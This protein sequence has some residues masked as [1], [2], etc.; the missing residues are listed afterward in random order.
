[1]NNQRQNGDI[2]LGCMDSIFKIIMIIG[3][4]V[5]II[6]TFGRSGVMEGTIVVVGGFALIFFGMVFYFKKQQK[7]EKENKDKENIE[8]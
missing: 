5:L 6:F 7:K 2:F 8:Q 4:I 3:C 1:M